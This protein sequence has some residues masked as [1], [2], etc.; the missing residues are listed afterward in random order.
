M[1]IEPAF[2]PGLNGLRAGQD[3]LVLT[4]LHEARRDVLAVHP[5]D[6]QTQPKAG[7][8][9]TRSADRPNPI[10]L[11]PVRLP[12]IEAVDGTPVIDIKPL[13]ARR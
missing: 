4:W 6:D 7:V 1:Q 2:L 3:I 10:G 9:A 8:F 13:L 5:R 12:S 11:H